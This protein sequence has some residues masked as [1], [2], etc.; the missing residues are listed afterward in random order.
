MWVMSFN[1]RCATA[2]GDGPHLWEHRAD[3]VRRYLRQRNPDLLGLQEAVAAQA[4]AVRDA[5]PGHQHHG[6]GRDD[7]IGRGEFASMLF[8]A[9][10]FERLDG[11]HQWLSPSPGKPG[12]PA[13]D[14]GCTRMFSWLR[15]RDRGTDQ[16]I[17][18]MNTHWD[19]V[20]ERARLHSAQQ[21]RRFA[22]D[23]AGGAM[24]LITGDF[25][26]TDRDPPHALLCDDAG[27]GL[28]ELLDAQRSCPMTD[29]GG[30]W[31]GFTGK[32]DGERIDWIVHSGALRARR[33]EIDR[34][35][36]AGVYLSD[37]FPLVAEMEPIGCG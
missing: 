15:L 9:E 35:H 8:R 18:W 2:R 17:L 23:H 30:T 22:A 19:H 33:V 16:P 24:V 21:L 29:P 11:G 27:D 34:L 10:R 37:H 14:A 5:L 12:P 25:N 3:M 6:V 28:G 1:I 20:G 31:H 4:R 7:G 26:C 36:E 13:W 32:T